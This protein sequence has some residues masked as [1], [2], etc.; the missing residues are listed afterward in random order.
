MDA[1]ARRWWTLALA[2]FLLI[3]AGCERFKPHPAASAPATTPPAATPSE[4][5]TP[6]KLTI[7]APKIA[8][9]QTVA[10]VNQAPL[11]IHDVTQ[12]VEELRLV[13]SAPDWEPTPEEREQLVDDLVGTEL[14][15]RD[16]ITRGL[17]RDPEIQARLWY[18]QRRFLADEWLRREQTALRVTPQEIEA[19]YNV[20]KSYYQLPPRVRV[21]QLA[22]PSEQQ[23]RQLL[24]QLLEGVDFAPLAK[25][26]SIDANAA[27]GGE[28]GWV[29]RA[30]DKE[31][32]ARSGAALEGNVLFPEAESVVFALEVDQSSQVVKGPGVGGQPHAYYLFQA[33]EKQPGR[34]KS[35]TE[36]Q[37]EIKALLSLQ[38][39]N[40]KLQRLRSQA[41]VE[42]HKERLKGGP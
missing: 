31:L 28:L 18:F 15:A 3:T 5:S 10:L 24:K 39:L 22:V 2:T 37:D 11:S 32:Y 14:M 23:A 26:H 7:T 41:T 25:T 42:T 8:D 29:V 21:R 1:N 35:L 27:T 13:L 33:A 30:S 9:A 12:R 16:S 6:M 19:F 34:Q 4:A 17:L 20:N 40:E 38:Q 36:V